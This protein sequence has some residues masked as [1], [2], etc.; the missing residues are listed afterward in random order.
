MIRKSGYRF[1]EKIMLI[2][3]ALCFLGEWFLQKLGRIAPRA[4]R[5]RI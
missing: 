3:C 4:A 1:S 2:P 5:T